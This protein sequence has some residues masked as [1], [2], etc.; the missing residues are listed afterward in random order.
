MDAAVAF[1]VTIVSRVGC[2]WCT[3]VKDFLNARNVRFEEI[4][5]HPS[6]ASYESQREY[7]F[8]RSMHHS[9]PIV[10]VNGDCIG[11]H[12]ATIRFF[13]RA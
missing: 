11:G 13:N 6:S 7:W 10:F 1:D 5:L 12:D 3:R 4:M 8:R 2:M 9:F